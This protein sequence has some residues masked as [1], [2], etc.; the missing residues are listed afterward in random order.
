MLSYRPAP[1]NP[2]RSS[3]LES[4]RKMSVGASVK[5]PLAF[6]GN[7]VTRGF[8]RSSFL[9]TNDNAR[10]AKF[11]TSASPIPHTTSP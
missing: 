4:E 5:S 6:E 8:D 2:S 7:P 3:P 1:A 10:P 9:A 11:P